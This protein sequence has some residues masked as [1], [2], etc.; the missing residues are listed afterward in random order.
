[1]DL[2]VVIDAPT[3]KPPASVNAQLFA[4]APLPGGGPVI[5]QPPVSVP[6]N[7]VEPPGHAKSSRNT[8]RFCVPQSLMYATEISTVLP[9]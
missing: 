4:L 7:E 5:C 1:M 8:P 6:S 2:G 3:G 9:A